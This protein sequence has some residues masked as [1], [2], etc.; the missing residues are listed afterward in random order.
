MRETPPEMNTFLTSL[1][2][3]KMSSTWGQSAWSRNRPSE[4][5]RSAFY[6]V[7]TK[8][9]KPLESFYKW[10]VGVVDGDGT[11]HFSK[12]QKGYWTFFFKV[13]QSNYNLRLL[14]FIKKM[15]G[16][17]RCYCFQNGRISDSRHTTTERSHSTYF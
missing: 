13:G 3:V 17:G 8:T 12:T 9:T 16:C 7:F 1:E 15:L 6:S 2:N 5:T 4:T 10:L 11:F 14:Y